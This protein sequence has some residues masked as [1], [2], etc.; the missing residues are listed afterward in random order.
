M[1]TRE[2]LSSI[3]Q[4]I[5]ICDRNGFIIY[6]NDAYEQFVG[7]SLSEVQGQPIRKIRPHTMISK[8]LRTKKPLENIYREE[9]DQIYFASIYPMLQNGE[10][11]GTISL[12]TQVAQLQLQ[13]E[14]AGLTLK[15]RTRLFERQEIEK[16]LKIYG[17]DLK[18][19][20]KTAEM[21]G[22]SLSGL[23]AKLQEGA[24]EQT[25]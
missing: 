22:I 18:G 7:H 6:F 2:I 9:D 5:L 17:N 14:S 24:E 20:K 3:Q 19:K 8:V 25:L 4:G 13:D 10:V 1:N 15:E 16:L 12:V 11:T 21:L 23:Y